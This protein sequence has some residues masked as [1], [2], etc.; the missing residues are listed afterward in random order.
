[1]AKT[2]VVNI[3]GDASKLQASLGQ[4]ESGIQKFGKAAVKVGA[5]ITG[6]GLAFG[7][8]GEDA[9]EHN[10]A[11]AQTAA[12]IK[13]TGGAAGV[14]AADVSA[15]SEKLGKMAVVDDDVTR[16]GVNLLLT[17][18]NI[19]KDVFP[20][21]SQAVVDMTAA[22]NN[23]MVTAEG[24]K[25]TTIQV[26]K[27]LQDP[28][29]GLTALRKVGVSFT[30]QQK[31]QI[32]AMVEAGDVA[33]AQRMILAELSKEFGGSAKAS[34]DNASA[35]QRLGVVLGDLRE[36]IGGVVGGM[37]TWM[38]TMGPMLAGIGGMAQASSSLGGVFGA[39]SGGVRALGGAFMAVMAPPAGLIILGIAAVVA[40][41]ILLVKHWDK[42][43][44]AF[45]WVVESFKIGVGMI[46]SAWAPV[47]AFFERLW[48]GIKSTFKG[49]INWVIDQLN[50][51]IK[52][53]NEVAK[54]LGR[55]PGVPTI[56][57]PT[58]PHL[59][60]GGIVNRPTLALIGEAGPEAVVPLRG[61]G[62]VGGMQVT[63]NVSGAGDPR[64]V[65]VAVR[66]E[67]LRLGRR[68]GSV[69]LA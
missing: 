59:A 4:A 50:R 43:R 20:E 39:L 6:L 30:D 37:S 64:S 52:A 47:G 25:G 14:T 1:M 65:A 11:V 24:L 12:V 57:L 23:G 48:G 27:A 7:R 33:G 35:Q 15:L 55:L 29:A 51:P 46:M 53:F 41:V 45:N 5:G 56:S 9:A 16:S 54:T 40:A 60:E 38:V 28:I 58:I 32:K 69:G 62:G 67:L 8:L 17:F 13:S 68:N 63:I 2:I 36:R 3:V 31:D 21:A 49:A 26:G 34:G 10:K 66:E 61:A 19:G 18:T 42:V 22:M 44:A